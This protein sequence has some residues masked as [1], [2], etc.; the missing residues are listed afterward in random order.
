MLWKV[1]GVIVLVWLAFT[2]VG[3]IIK[4]LFWLAVIGGVLFV[5]TLAYGALK[6]GKDQRS[7]R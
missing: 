4:G 6:G 5:G 3:V 7:L 2:V 1:I